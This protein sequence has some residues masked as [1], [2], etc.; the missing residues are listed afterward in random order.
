MRGAMYL[1]VA[2]G[3]GMLTVALVLLHFAVSSPMRDF[4]NHV[5]SIGETSVVSISFPVERRDEIGILA[6]E[7]NRMLERLR[8]FQEELELMVKERTAELTT[9]NRRLHQEIGER[10]Q[11][12][13]KARESEEKLARSKRM[14]FLGLMAGG[15]A[16]DLNNILSGVVSY[17]DLLLTRPHRLAQVVRR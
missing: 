6:S 1:V 8:K 2:A 13:E 14:E 10:K 3:L 4:T 17:P 16:H 5:V 15:I 12:E 7:F 11:A 9:A